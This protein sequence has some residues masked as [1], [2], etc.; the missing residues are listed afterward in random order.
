M[1]MCNQYLSEDYVVILQ[2][3]A[4]R[5]TD[6]HHPDGAVRLTSTE[7]KQGIG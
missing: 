1:K 4:Q 3:A 2:H 6:L 5:D 7:L